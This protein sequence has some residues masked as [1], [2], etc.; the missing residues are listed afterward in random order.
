MLWV[1]FK[2]NTIYNILYDNAQF[3]CEGVGANESCKTGRVGG[4]GGGGAKSIIA[5]PDI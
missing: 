1:D 5:A 3:P 4:G 2:I